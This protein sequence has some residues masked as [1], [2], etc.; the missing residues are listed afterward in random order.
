MTAVAP[1]PPWAAQP[2]RWGPG[3][4]TALVVGIV[5]LIPGIGLLVGGGALFY[6]DRSSRTTDGFVL[7]S[8]E[9]FTAAG[10]ALSSDTLDLS[11]GASW[12]PV[13][14]ALGDARIQVTGDQ[15]RDVF[16]GIAPVDDAKAYLNGVGHTVVADIGADLTGAALVT[17]TGGPPSGPP[18]DQDFWVAK[19]SGTGQQRLTWTPANGDWVLV[20][21]NADASPGVA[22]QARAGATVPALGRLAWGVLAG[23]FVL[24]VGG[25]LLVVLAAR[26]RSGPVQP[27]TPATAGPP[28]P[29]SAWLPPPRPADPTEAHDPARPAG[30]GTGS[31]PA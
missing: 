28:G 4:I 29:P 18:G 19:T 12:L 7:S 17:V 13:S 23:G 22:V 15:G 20:V 11:T 31:P 24:T 21:M 27:G 25:V 16:V 9:H 30:P 26:R 10:Y 14:S 8:S 2:R 1:P 3:R 5:L 6:V